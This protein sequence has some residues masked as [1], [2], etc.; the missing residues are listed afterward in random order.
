[1]AQKRSRLSDFQR[2]AECNSAIRQ[3]E[4]LRYGRIAASKSRHCQNFSKP[5]K[6]GI[7][8]EASEII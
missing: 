4:N 3:I 1:M 5:A 8:P 7:I 6:F 2:L